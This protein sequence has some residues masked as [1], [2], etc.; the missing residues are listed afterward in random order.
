[1]ALLL[2]VYFQPM[3]R[4]QINGKIEKHVFKTDTNVTEECPGQGT[5]C[6]LSMKDDSSFW[7]S[8]EAETAGGRSPSARMY[9][10]SSSQ[11]KFELHRQV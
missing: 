6:Q 5:V 8:L 3:N 1:M 7:T 9:I 11:R 2:N 10:P 4:R